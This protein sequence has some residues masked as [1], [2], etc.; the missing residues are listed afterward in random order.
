MPDHIG[1]SR[2]LFLAVDAWRY[3]ARDGLQQLALQE[4]L[5][6][7]VDA[8][9]AVAGLDPADRQRQVAGDGFLDVI[10][11]SGAEL[12]LV[13]PFVR[14]LD[15]RLA[16]FN[17]DRR[18]EARLRLRLAIH[19]GGAVPGACGFASDGPVHV[20]RL[21]DAKPVKAALTAIP[22]ANLVQVLSEPIFGSVRQRLTSLSAGDFTPVV[23]DEPEKDFRET[24]WIRVPGIDAARLS[25]LA[26]PDALAISIAHTA[27]PDVLRRATLTAFDAA[28]IPRPASASGTDFVVPLSSPDS[29]SGV[30]GVWLHH[31]HEAVRASGRTAV[32]VGIAPGR[33]VGTAR[34]LATGDAAS[35]VLREVADASVVVVVA[36][37]AHRRFVAGSHARMV[38]PGSYRRTGTEPESWLRVLGYS[39]APVVGRR[40]PHAEAPAPPD[41]TAG[42][43]SG[44]V[45]NIGSAVIHGSYVNG[46]VHHSGGLFR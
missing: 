24:A 23:V 31:L 43:S 28:G 15:S 10:S 33:D 44:P 8:A 21:R 18:P 14:E 17:H 40:A 39:M 3:G 45:S 1:F 37:A 19:H 30:L 7:A 9:G 13:D 5:S 4:A 22:E 12:A 16:W 42:S 25:D 2:V 34:E 46:S 36:D 29:G 38:M 11:D 26:E 32:S 27:E 41:R 6:A 20:C 35:A